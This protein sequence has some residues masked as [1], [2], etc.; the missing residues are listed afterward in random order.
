MYFNSKSISLLLTWAQLVCGHYNVPVKNFSSSWAD[1]RA[2]LC[3]IAFYFRGIISIRD[4]GKSKV[5]FSSFFF[6]LFFFSFFL[7]LLIFERKEECFSMNPN[8]I[9]FFS[10]II[11]TDYYRRGYG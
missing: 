6:I 2:F 3:L 7:I 9:H 10:C 5:S 4:I 1:G 11:L 8:E